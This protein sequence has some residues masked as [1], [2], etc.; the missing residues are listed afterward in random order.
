MG[1]G[2]TAPALGDT[3]LVTPTSR[4]IVIASPIVTGNAVEYRAFY[5]A[6]DITADLKETG[7]FGHST[8][9]STIGTGEL[10]ARAL[11][12]FNNASSP[13]DA[14][15]VW[16]G[17]FWL[18]SFSVAFNETPT[19]VG[20]V[21]SGDESTENL[22]NSSYLQIS[23]AASRPAQG[24]KGAL[25]W[26]TD[27]KVLSFDDGSAWVDA[28]P[29]VDF[30]RFTSSGT[31]TKPA[32][33]T[34]V[35]VELIGPGGGGGSIAEGGGGGGGGGG[36]AISREVYNASDLAATHTV[37]VPA[38]GAAG[39]SG[40]GN[41]VAG[42]STEF[43]GTGVLQK[44]FGGGGGEGGSSGSGGGGG[45]ASSGAVGSGGTGGDGGD[46]TIQS[47]THGNS[48][49][50]RGAKGGNT[51]ADGSNSENG[52]GGGA[53]GDTTL[54]AST[55]GK[56]GGSSIGGAGGGGGGSRASDNTNNGG[57]GGQWGAYAAGG[58]AVGDADG[59]AT[60]TRR[61]FGAGDGGAG[62]GGTTSTS[63]AGGAGG[64]PGGG[65][66][67][68]S[69]NNS[70]SGAGGAGARGEIRIWAW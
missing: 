20:P 62:A 26:A 40:G 2:V 66:G 16:D 64:A 54:G 4:K 8:A 41:G 11:I 57:D 1:T 69:G 61:N 34:V 48:L 50:G 65:G 9:T 37:T 12:T 60:G 55:P 29:L 17:H 42:G 10:F 25:H 24:N 13:N 32:G 38:G 44:A 3:A 27:T 68:G 59:E 21:A 70:N 5:P 53:G 22:M 47:S 46:P 43:T 45:K 39:S 35:V 23:V 18:T 6:A 14:T 7:I 49:G 33:V 31:W 58:G 56:D 30:Q 63:F 51:D 28:L 52:G 19:Y 67:G 15:V 36:G